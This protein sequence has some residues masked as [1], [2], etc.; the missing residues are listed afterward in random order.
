MSRSAPLLLLLGLLAALFAC[1]APGPSVVLVTLHAVPPAQLGAYGGGDAS[2]HLDRVA[3]AG[4]VHDAAY[5]TF[6]AAGPAVISMLTGYHASH[7]GSLEDGE[8]VS[9]ERAFRALPNVLPHVGYAAGAFVGSELVSAEATG[10]RGFEV[11][12]GPARGWRPGAAAVAEALA[13]LDA[14]PQR[15]VLL[16]VH[17]HDAGEPGLERLADGIRAVDGALGGLLE[18]LDAR[19]PEPPVIV[20]AGDLSEDS[21]DTSG[22]IE[23]LLESLR[24]PLVV[25]GPGVARGRAASLASIRDV[26]TTVLQSAGLEDPEARWK[27]RRDLRHAHTADRVVTVELPESGPQQ[28]RER[29]FAVAV[30]DGTQGLLVPGGAGPAAIG[31]SGRRLAGF[32][33]PHYEALSS[34]PG[35]VPMDQE[36]RRALRQALG[37]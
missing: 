28:G 33:L 26:Y 7:H 4:L 20:I 13:W 15:P 2:P 21:P 31:V 12:E 8:K 24:V 5:T 25:Q 32:A 18:G 17:L 3:A 23:A 36:W 10:L 1:G 14:T 11:Y 16:W 6:P 34:R 19:L 9:L 29:R 37:D 22:P 35:S 30:W 27:D